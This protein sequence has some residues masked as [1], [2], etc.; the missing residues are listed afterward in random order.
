MPTRQRRRVA[1]VLASLLAATGMAFTVP[2]ASH[3]RG[4][5]DTTQIGLPPLIKRYGAIAYSHDGAAGKARRHV[6]KLGAEQLALERCGAPNCIV[7]ST[8]TRC[9]A[10][11]HDG[12]TYH[13]GIGLTRRDAER[14]AIDMLGGGWAVD[15]ACN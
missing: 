8:F 14:H 1:L 12:T 2:P 15:W 3:A 5:Q 10:V 9:G 13:G 7:V 4:D 6:S 11:A